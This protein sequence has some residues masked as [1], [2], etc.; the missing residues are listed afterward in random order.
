MEDA[1][2]RQY[3][4]AFLFR[5]VSLVAV[6]LGLWRLFPQ[7]LSLGYPF[8]SIA[9]RMLVLILAGSAAGTFLGGFNGRI[10]PCAVVGAAVGFMIAIYLFW[11]QIEI[12]SQV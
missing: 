7:E 1:K 4:L 12:W 8:H 3:S 11:V 6:L 5:Q 9:A 2:P 10:I